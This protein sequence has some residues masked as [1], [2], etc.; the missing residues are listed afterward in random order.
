[1]TLRNQIEQL[2]ELEKDLIGDAVMG[3]GI[4][5]V[6]YAADWKLLLYF[7]CARVLVDCYRGISNNNSR[8]EIIRQENIQDR[9]GGG[10]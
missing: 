2:N 6:G 4:A 9:F 1:M 10:R 8:N 7:G 5:S 3:I